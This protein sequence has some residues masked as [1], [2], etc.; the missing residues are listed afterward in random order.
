VHQE[1]SA[2]HSLHP[3][4]SQLPPSEHPVLALE[5]NEDRDSL[6]GL[7]EVQI[8]SPAVKFSSS[9]SLKEFPDGAKDHVGEN[10]KSK[11]CKGSEV[12]GRFYTSEPQDLAY[13]A[14]RE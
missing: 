7:G 11:F 5:W 1:G 4:N 9:D 2:P 10:C 6:H 12:I 14:D 3:P 13:K 8:L